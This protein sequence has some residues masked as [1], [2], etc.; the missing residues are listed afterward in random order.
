[1]CLL[2]GVF[3]LKFAQNQ[4]EFEIKGA[5]E[6]LNVF[7]SQYCWMKDVQNENY[8]EIKGAGELLNVSP[9]RCFWMKGV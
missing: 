3:E 5:G 9:F 7:A 2:S 1:M 6:L 8:F 4:N